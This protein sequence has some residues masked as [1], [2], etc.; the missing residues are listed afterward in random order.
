MTA[1]F[2]VNEVKV[3]DGK[4]VTTKREPVEGMEEAIVWAEISTMFRAAYAYV[5]DA[6]GKEV[7]RVESLDFS[8]EQKTQ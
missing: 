5:L 2:T 7:Y 8:Y 1:M 6:H 3:I 4:E